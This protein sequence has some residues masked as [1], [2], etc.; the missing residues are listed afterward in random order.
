VR[1]SKDT[2]YD[3]DGWKDTAVTKPPPFK[4]GFVERLQEGVVR[5]A[6]DEMGGD[7]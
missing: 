5:R 2:V 4:V 6:L 3:L 7:N 1:P